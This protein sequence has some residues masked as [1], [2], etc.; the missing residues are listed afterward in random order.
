MLQAIQ[1][2]TFAFCDGCIKLTEHSCLSPLW[3][4][5]QYWEQGRYYFDMNN[6]LLNLEK[7]CKQY[8]VKPLSSVQLQLA[9]VK[10]ECE[11]LKEIQAMIMIL[12]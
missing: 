11:W 10:V 8:N 7:R 5:I 1:A 4:T 2:C 3:S 9:L 12:S 6:F